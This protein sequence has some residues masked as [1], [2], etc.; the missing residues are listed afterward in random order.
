MTRRLT[1][2]GG[3]SE[4]G[5]L[6]DPVEPET[7]PPGWSPAKH[8][9]WRKPSRWQI[10]MPRL[11]LMAKVLLSL[12]LLV[13]VFKVLDQSPP[14]ER[15][16]QHLELPEHPEQSEQPEQPEQRLEQVEEDPPRTLTNDDVPPMTEAQM[17]EVGKK[18][19]WIWKDFS[20]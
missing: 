16:P 15:P 20:T 6:A 12:I 13:L 9:F 8:D 4:M 14:P 10:C 11:R 2:S 5:L 7:P 19:Q 17:V 1:L 3:R 18:E